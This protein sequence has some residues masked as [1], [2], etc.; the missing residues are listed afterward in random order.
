MQHGQFRRTLWGCRARLGSTTAL[1]A[2][3]A[4]ADIPADGRRLA[5]EQLDA[6]M[7]IFSDTAMRFREAGDLDQFREWAAL[8]I[9]AARILTPTRARG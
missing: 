8:A 5:T 4:T 7:T 6:Y 3:R 1:R 2:E 9:E